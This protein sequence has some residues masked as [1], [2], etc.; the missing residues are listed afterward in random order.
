MSRDSAAIIIVFA[1][2]R[3]VVLQRGQVV[4]GN[5]RR[6]VD[7]IGP[8]R[9]EGAEIHVGKFALPQFA[10]RHFHGHGEPQVVVGAVEFVEQRFDYVPLAV[11]GV[12]RFEPGE[13]QSR[14]LLPADGLGPL[15]QPLLKI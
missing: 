3:P 12:P 6:E 13:L 1:L 4:E 8:A 5:P 2:I 9:S 11:F 10:Q 7:G 14:P 15:L